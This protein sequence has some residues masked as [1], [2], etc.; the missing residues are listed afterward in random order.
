MPLTTCK[1][2]G[3]WATPSRANV[4]LPVGVPP[5]VAAATTAMKVIG[6]PTAA[7]LGAIVRV[8]VVAVD[9]ASAVT[10]AVC[11]AVI[12]GLVMDVTRTVTVPVPLVAMP[13][14]IRNAPVPR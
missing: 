9:A 7:G 3:D 1:L 10:V 4:T 14:W 11:D 8:V 6:S 2:V 13:V 5:P 12:A